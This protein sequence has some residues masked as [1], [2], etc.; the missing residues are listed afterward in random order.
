MHYAIFDTLTGHIAQICTTPD[1]SEITPILQS[2]QSFVAVP[3]TC[4][5]ISHYV[6]N[7][8]ATPRPAQPTALDG[9]TLRG[10]PGPST[11]YINTEPYPCDDQTVELEFDQPGTYTVRVEVWPY[12]DKE[13][14]VEVKAL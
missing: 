2:G 11:V 1:P 6:Q 9:T 3:S 14:T 5:D 13:F 12:L 4:T 10:I 7:D 8:K